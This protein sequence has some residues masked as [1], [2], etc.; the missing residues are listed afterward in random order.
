MTGEVL[1]YNEAA[2]GSA[3]RRR[4]AA[5][6]PGIVVEYMADSQLGDSESKA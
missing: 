4:A 3:R 2:A 6:E 1:L 5:R